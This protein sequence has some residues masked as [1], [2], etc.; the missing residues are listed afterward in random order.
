MLPADLYRLNPQQWTLSGG[1]QETGNVNAQC[2]GKRGDQRPVGRH[3]ERERQDGGGERIP[4]DHPHDV[5]PPEDARLVEEARNE[6]EGGEEDAR[7]DE[8]LRVPQRALREA[9]GAH[10]E[11][12]PVGVER[13]DEGG[14][15]RDADEHQA[16]N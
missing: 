6:E 7:A 1:K 10:L 16:L 2:E 4:Q 14:E 8:A 12:V 9:F 11:S 3:T 15:A 13:E 5:V